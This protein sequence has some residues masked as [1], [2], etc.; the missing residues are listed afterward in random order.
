MGTQIAT[1][2]LVIALGGG[3]LDFRLESVPSEA[4]PA[5]AAALMKDK[6]RVALCFDPTV[7]AHC[8]RTYAWGQKDD[9]WREEC[10]KRGYA[11]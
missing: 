4:C 9:P 8:Q 1:T 10:A 3:P 2:L 11:E 5:L 6:G 7:M